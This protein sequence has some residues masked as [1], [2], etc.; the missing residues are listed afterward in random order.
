MSGLAHVTLPD[1]SDDL[2]ITEGVNGLMIAADTTG[3]GHYTEYPSEKQTIALQV[4]FTE[5]KFP[6]HAIVHDG[7]CREKEKDEAALESGALAVQ[8]A[9]LL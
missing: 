8:R 1:A 3:I 6:A 5:G 7:V 2:W 4:P 9:A